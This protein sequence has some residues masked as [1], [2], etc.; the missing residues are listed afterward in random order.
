MRNKFTHATITFLS[1]F[2]LLLLI[3]LPTPL[4]QQEATSDQKIDNDIALARNEINAARERHIKLNMD[5]SKAEEDSFDPLYRQFSIDLRKLGDEEVAIIKDFAEHYFNMTDNQ[6]SELTTRTLEFE[7][8]RTAL[9]ASYV[10]KVTKALS[11]K[12]AARFV[13]LELYF[14]KAL[15]IQLLQQ[16]PLVLK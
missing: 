2:T 9:L 12:Q 3:R 15:D 10:P 13:Q 7:R 16:L 1:A 11:A 8:K 14:D 4:A 5:L 6:A